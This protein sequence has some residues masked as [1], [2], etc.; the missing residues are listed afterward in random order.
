MARAMEGAH[1]SGDGRDFATVKPGMI[2]HRV[3]Q[4]LIEKPN[5]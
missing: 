2:R 4:A 1:D 3:R 5:A